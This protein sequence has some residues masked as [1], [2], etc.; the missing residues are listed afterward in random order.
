VFTASII[1]NKFCFN[2][3]QRCFKEKDGVNSSSVELKDNLAG[4]FGL[5]DICGLLGGR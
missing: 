4:A 3:L 2:R 1:R 5:K